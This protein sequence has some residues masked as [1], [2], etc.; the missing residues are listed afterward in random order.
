M[1]ESTL[2]FSRVISTKRKNKFEEERKADHLI[3]LPGRNFEM[4]DPDLA[5]H[6]HHP[7]PPHPPAL[8]QVTAGENAEGSGAPPAPARVLHHHPVRKVRRSNEIL[9]RPE[10]DAVE[11]GGPSLRPRLGLLVQVS[12]SSSAMITLVLRCLKRWAGRV[13]K[14]WGQK[15]RELW[16]PSR[17]TQA[18]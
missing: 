7:H 2:P 18:I 12:I 6:H 10:E 15:E 14:D 11:T 1:M 3:N 8:G 5:L 17:R 13:A 4:E 9:P 16:S